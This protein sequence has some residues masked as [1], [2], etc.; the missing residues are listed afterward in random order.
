[1][2]DPEEA[3]RLLDEIYQDG[4]GLTDWEADFLDAQL[5]KSDDGYA[6]STKEAALIRRIHAERVRGDR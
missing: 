6:P 1:M 2:M 3:A 5:R 4:K